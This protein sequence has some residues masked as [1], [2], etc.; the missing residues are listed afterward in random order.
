MLYIY[1]LISGLQYYGAKIL[2]ISN[3]YK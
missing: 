2:K 1:V 3:V